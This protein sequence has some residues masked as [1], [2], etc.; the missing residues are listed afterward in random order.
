MQIPD[1]ETLES[2]RQGIEGVVSARYLEQQ[3][4]P[5]FAPT[6]LDTLSP[7]RQHAELRIEEENDQGNVVRVSIHMCLASAVA[8]LQV[9]EALLR[10]SA[11]LTPGNRARVLSQCSTD[12]RAAATAALRASSMLA[13]KQR[14][15]SDSLMEIRL[16]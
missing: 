5:Y 13:G 9:S 6:D 2:A 4:V 10:D 8:A 11:Q 15:E 12:M 16:L 1:L 7:A 3:A 14:P